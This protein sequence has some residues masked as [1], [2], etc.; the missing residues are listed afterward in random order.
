MKGLYLLHEKENASL[1]EIH[2]PGPRKQEG[3]RG[4]KQKKTL[5]VASS[6]VSR[7]DLV[8]GKGSMSNSF[9]LAPQDSGDYS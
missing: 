8:P 2:G 1:L 7:Q 5:P 3:G 4:K 9:P 6:E